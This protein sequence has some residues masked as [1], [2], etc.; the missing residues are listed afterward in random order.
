MQIVL[1]IF[2]S[3]HD[4]LSS[5]LNHSAVVTSVIIKALTQETICQIQNSSWKS[6]LTA[7]WNNIRHNYGVNSSLIS[8]MAKKETAQPIDNTGTT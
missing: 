3:T 6:S 8:Q 4:S 7:L 1:V 5:P 2:I